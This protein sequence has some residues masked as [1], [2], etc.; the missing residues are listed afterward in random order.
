MPLAA[1][2]CFRVHVKIALLA[3]LL[4]LYSFIGLAGEVI[5]T[6]D[7]FIQTTGIEDGLPHELTHRIVQD[8]AGYLWF[9]TS[10][11]L[12]RYDGNHLQLISSPLIRNEESDVIYAIAQ[13]SEGDLWAAPNCGGLVQFVNGQFIQRATKD[14]FPA[15]PPT[16]LTQTPDGAFWVGY[17]EAKLLRWKDGHATWFTHDDGLAAGQTISLATDRQ[18]KT[19]IASDSFL[20]SYDQGRLA[21]RFEKPGTKLRLGAARSGGVWVV[22]SEQL[23][24]L[25][26]GT[27]TL[28][29][30][31]TPWSSVAGTPSVV[32][33]DSGGTVWLGTKGL[34]LYRF[35][36]GAFEK[37]PASHPWVTDLNE[38]R[39]KNVWVTTRGGGVNRLRRKQFSV[40]DARAGLPESVSS[41]VCEDSAGN[42][43]IAYDGKA[44]VRLDRKALEQKETFNTDP[45]RLPLLVCPDHSSN[46]WVATRTSLMRWPLG[47]EAIAEDIGTP[48]NGPLH[49]LFCRRNG[50][51]WACGERGFVA[52]WHDGKWTRYDNLTNVLAL[53]MVRCVGEDNEGTVWIAMNNGGMLKFRNEQFTLLGP[54]DGLPPSMVRNMFLDSAG[55]LWMATTR[56]GLLLCENNAFRRV[57]VSEGLPDEMVDQ[58][59]E[60]DFH[61]LWF[62]TQ[63]G[64]YYITRDELFQCAS[65]KISRVSPVSYGRE[66]GLLGYPAITSYQPTACKSSDGRLWFATYKGVLSVDP[67]TVKLE[68]NPPPVLVDEVLLDDKPVPAEGRL[69]LPAKARKLE[70][71]LSVI[72]FSAPSQVKIRHWLENFDSAWV[73]ER[74]QRYFTYPKLPPGEYTLRYSACN[75]EGIWNTQIMPLTLVVKPYWWQIRWLQLVSGGAFLAL[76]ILSVRA[77]SH[78]RLQLELERLEQKQTME[79]ER[80]RIAKNLHDDLGASLTELGLLADLARRN[81]A[82]LDKLK[83]V[84]GFL[85]ERVRGLARTLDTIVWTVNPTNDSL[86]ELAAYICEF[87]QE[88][89]SKTSIRCRLD[90]DE[91]IPH[92]PLS[93]EERSNLFLT[94]KEAINNVIK[95]SNAGEA[96]VEIKM[97]GNCFNIAIKD[98]GKG[99]NPAAPEN[100]RRN[101]LANMRFRIQEL[102]GDFS[103]SS[104]PGQGTTVS[105][106]ISVPIDTLPKTNS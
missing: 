45:L 8:R 69:V 76:L 92:H 25:E 64:L 26:N 22:G 68:T 42:L 53:N 14:D 77:W 17:F 39:E 72:Y 88:L 1:R 91:D 21:R 50:E 97:S 99:F 95:H 15:V 18:G 31:N 81:G 11:G 20:G 80:A 85:S 66:S 104:V 47:K 106:S 83:D 37:M 35:A 24:K 41:S 27:L 57:T 101:G 33:E 78:R 58:I 49:S 43:W 93:P 36:N 60:D 5:E 82:T 71:R 51:M 62:G 100:A 46:V 19:W 67:K 54:Q 96:W 75:P 63:V 7:Y 48:A 12:V 61:R 38:D 23:Q 55:H 89:F 9:S 34:G 94:A 59:V 44:V 40:L 56:D 2:I 3:W 52:R 10:G 30:T 29:T 16:F 102:N 13:S 6:R 74:N 65:G 79:K 90:V 86:H 98:N 4:G 103:V 70:V 87:S 105:I 73:E 84:T 32:F 28:V